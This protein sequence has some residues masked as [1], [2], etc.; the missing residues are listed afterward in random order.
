MRNAISACAT[1]PGAAWIKA[2]PPP[3]SGLSAPRGRETKRRSTILACTTLPRK[4][5]KKPPPKSRKTRRADP[6]SNIQRNFNNQAP[7]YFMVFLNLKL[8]A[9]L[10]FG[11]WNLEFFFRALI[12]QLRKF[13]VRLA[14]IN[15]FIR[16]FPAFGQRFGFSRHE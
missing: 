16:Q 7:N 3:S 4:R 12:L 5:R 13:R 1:R 9:S 8:G 14:G 6:S 10:K 15:G 11:G 2:T